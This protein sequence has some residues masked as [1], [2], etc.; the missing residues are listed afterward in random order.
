MEA[1]A[2]VVTVH[3]AYWG[4]LKLTEEGDKNSHVVGIGKPHPSSK[5]P[6]YRDCVYADYNATTPVY[7]GNLFSLI[8]VMFT[9]NL[10]YCHMMHEY[11]GT[12]CDVAFHFE[13]LWKSFFIPC[14][15]KDI[16]NSSE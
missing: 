9:D 6:L 15:R 5:L 10:L 4:L 3:S 16:E 1:M 11:R 14:I 8:D 7:E 2:L 13:Q 12:S